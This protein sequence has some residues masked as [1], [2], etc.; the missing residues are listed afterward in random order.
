MCA[1]G[2]TQAIAARAANARLSPDDL[3]LS[4]SSKCQRGQELGGAPFQTRTA[5]R[6]RTA[7]VS[8]L[9][10]LGVAEALSALGA[11]ECSSAAL[12]AA[13]VERVRCRDRRF[14]AFIRTYD[15]EALAAARDS[16]E[17]RA[18]G[19]A[20]PLEGVPIAVKDLIGVQG[21]PLTGDS[22][23]L[24]G[25]VAA[26]DSAVWARLRAAG[27]V[28]VGHLH[29]GELAYGHWGVNPWD[30]T[31]SPGG[32]SSGSGIALAARLVPAAL[33]TDTR[34]S[35]RMPAAFTGCTA[36]KPTN[37]LISTAGCIPLAFSYDTVGPMA[38]SAADCAALLAAIVPPEASGW[39]DRLRS[40]SPRPGPRPLAG[41]RVGVPDIASELSAGVASAFKEFCDLIEALGASCVAFSWPTN[42]LEA[43]L[44][45]GPLWWSILGSEAAIVHEQFQGLE[46]LYRD[47]FRNLFRPVMAPVTAGQY[48]HAQ[49]ARVELRARWSEVFA[50]LGLHA[51]LHPACKDEAY[52]AGSE[53]STELMS[54][55]MFGVWSDAGFPVLSIPAGRSP[56][57]GTPVGLQLVGLPFCEPALLQIGIDIQA[58]SDFHSA[59]PPGLDDDG[60]DYIGPLRR[61]SGRAASFVAPPDPFD[62][63]LTTAGRPRAGSCPAEQP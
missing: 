41:L 11:G 14:G 49:Q 63:L 62:V 45:A 6:R 58:N 1:G 39:P 61:E 9:A 28:L 20:R 35:V 25:N 56:T 23:L 46:H 26:E 31:I 40:A 18:R 21:K 44:D 22:A 38:R 19:A 33:G 50:G 42:P 2:E 60:P 16:D 4:G 8:Q 15:E 54:R 36:L 29:C 32:S 30:A 12:V 59:V 52:P 55:L 13:C 47:E 27:M 5:P 3:Q 51:I 17:R 53:V 10:D 7:H 43:M 34:G 24:E 37:G 48:L 57:D